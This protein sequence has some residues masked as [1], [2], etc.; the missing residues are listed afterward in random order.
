MIKP[1]TAS[2][3]LGR[4]LLMPTTS[5]LFDRS[6]CHDQTLGCYFEPIGPSECE[7]AHPAVP[8]F[9]FNLAELY[10]ACNHFVTAL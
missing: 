7:P 10:Q 8:Q 4:S 9:R 1:W 2:L 3:R 6:S 5:G